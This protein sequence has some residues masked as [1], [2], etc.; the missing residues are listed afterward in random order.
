VR[1]V[2]F[3]HS[4]V[5]D[6]N[7][8]NAHFL[9]GV[10]R[11]LKACGHEVI[12][13]ELRDGW[14]RRNLVAEQGLQSI[15]AFA[16]AFPNLGSVEYDLETLEL[17][18][19]LDRVDVVIVHEWNPP[20]LIERIGRHRA[21]A[22]TYSL[23]FH[24]THHRAVSARRDIDRLALDAYD[25][26]L[27]FGE[28]IRELYLER[29][30]ARRVWT[31]HEAADVRLFRPIEGRRREGDLVWVGNWG[32][33]ER[34]AELQAFLLEPVRHLELVAR[35]YGVRYPQHAL[36]KLAAAGAAYG[37]WLPNYRVPEVFGRFA[38]TVHVPRR[39]YARMLPGI[40]TIR[41]FEALACGI[42]LI[43]APWD[44]VEGLFTP[45]RDFLVAPDGVAMHEALRA[46]LNEPGLAEELAGHGV[47]TIR[48]RH[49]CGH[50]VEELLS[51][52]A[53]IRPERG[54]ALG[55]ANFRALAEA[56]A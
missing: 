55:R 32:D 56:V 47:R 37:G 52:C 28:V 39:P 26:I 10:V 43:S 34:T 48:E 25:G 12:V 40:P 27:A 33:G 4:L 46:V 16:A 53:S 49:T 3:Y 14:S 22:G 8:G 54:S 38:V 20:E 24:D 44:D 13:C 36:R 30:W 21:C 7:H 15:A 51:I 19:L 45:G 6:W 42:P 5:S 11:E 31:W 18:A 41:V 9:R 50:R 2:L 35:V 23:L 17:D 1:F 29:G